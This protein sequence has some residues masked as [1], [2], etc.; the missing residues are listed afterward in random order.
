MHRRVQSQPELATRRFVLA[1]LIAVAPLA[2]ATP[3]SALQ[4]SRT[5]S[6]ETRDGLTIQGDFTR[7]AH[8]QRLFPALILIHQ[9]NTDRTE[10]RPF[11]PRLTVAGFATLAYDIW[12]FGDSDPLPD[13]DI[14]WWEDPDAAPLDLEAALTFLR[15]I[16]GVDP[17]RV[18]VMG[19]SIGSNLAAMSTF[20]FSVRAAVS[21]SPNEPEMV[22]LSGVEDPA[23]RNALYVAGTLDRDGLNAERARSL[24]DQTAGRADTIIVQGSPAHGV[25]LFAARSTLM[26]EVIEWLNAALEARGPSVRLGRVR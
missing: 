21:L 10:W 16:E 12:G 1:G 14:P 26:D 13:P 3:A 2:L 4:D 6:F 19:G 20:R 8:V 24:A 18:A 9:G 15:T 25:S 23:V 5:V 22:G 17:D 7:P 11:V